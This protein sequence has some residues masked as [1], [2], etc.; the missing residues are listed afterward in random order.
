MLFYTMFENNVEQDKTDKP[1]GSEEPGSTVTPP[2]GD[3]NGNELANPNP[4]KGDDGENKGTADAT[5]MAGIFTMLAGLIG[6]NGFRRK[7]DNILVINFKI[8]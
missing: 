6:T 4:P 3:V 5:S 1:Q 7:I 8:I 2:S